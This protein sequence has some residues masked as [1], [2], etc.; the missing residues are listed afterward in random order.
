MAVRA[1]AKYAR[2]RKPTIKLKRIISFI[3]NMYLPVWFRVKCQPHIQSGSRHF[4]YMVELSQDLVEEARLVVQKVMSD[5]AHFAHAESIVIT[6]LADPRE[7]LRRKGV[8]HILA[9]RREHDPE[10][11]P[12]QFIPPS[13][14][15]QAN[16]YADLID[17]DGIERTEPPLTMDLSEDT[18]LSAMT[19]PLKL[20]S[21]K[22]HTQGVEKYMP[23]LEMAC[24][25]RAG[26]T[27]RHRFILSVDQSRVLVPQ[28]DT[29]K[30]D[31]KF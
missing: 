2:V 20:P 3:L 14:N 18:I 24:G 10:K 17:W 21:Y 15:F 30:D 4:H 27:A 8:L 22:N 9:A 29:K 1:L 16:V 31:A 26:Y 13:V 7:E 11:G 6:L 23:V 28:F 25:Q 12:R 19:K 5:N